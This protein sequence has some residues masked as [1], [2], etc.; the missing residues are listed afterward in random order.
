MWIPVRF[1]DISKKPERRKASCFLAVSL[2]LALFCAQGCVVTDKIEFKDAVNHSISVARNLPEETAAQDAIV[3]FSVYVQDEDVTD[4]E[5]NPIEGHLEI[6]AD[7]WTDPVFK[8]CEDPSLV[9][10]DDD[11]TDD[12]LSPVF[13][14][15]CDLNLETV[16]V[17]EDSLIAV[18]LVVSDLGFYQNEIREGAATAETVWTLRILQDGK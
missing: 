18:R 8:S 5:Q 4:P 7:Y 12:E 6:K 15:E 11:D 13:L 3:R 17:T 2:L 1:S 14:I 9:E 10:P 16:G